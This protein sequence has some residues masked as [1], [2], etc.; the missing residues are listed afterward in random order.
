[1]AGARCGLAEGEPPT[2]TLKAITTRSVE[3]LRAYLDGEQAAVGGRIVEAR[4]AY[5]RAIAA[6]S[7]FWFAYFRSANASGWAESDVDS[8]FKR[9]YWDHRGLLP[10][11]ERL[12]IEATDLDSGFVWR[13]ARLEALVR[14]YPDY[15]P[16][17]FMLGDSYVHA[18]PALGS[19]RADARRALERAV[20]L[21]PALVYAWGH[22]VWMYQADRDTAAA[23][24]ALDATGSAGRG[25]RLREGGASGRH[26][27]VRT[28]QALQTGSRAAGPLTDS[29]YRTALAAIAADGDMPRTTCSVSRRPLRRRKSSSTA[30]C[31]GE[32]RHGTSPISSSGSPL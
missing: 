6:D 18:F 15:W 5:G 32:T 24:H 23:V 17:W 7:S 10:R 14:E 26:A 3:A 28:V 19:T 16:A 22:L 2:P 31:S 8:L 11:R 9:A 20:A 4:A 29:L 30:A 25:G 13:R 27:R 1:M 21:N 12:L